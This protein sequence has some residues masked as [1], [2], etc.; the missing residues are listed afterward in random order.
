MASQHS[1]ELV[2][3]KDAGLIRS[4]ELA[5]YDAVLFYTT[6]DLTQPG[7][8]EGLFGGDGEPA[9]GP[10]G[11]QDLVAWVENGGAFLGFH[12]ATDTFHDPS[13]APSPYIEVLGGEF[14]T[15]G[16]QFPGK[17]DVVDPDHSTMAHIPKSWTLLDEW[18]VFKNVAVERVHV[19]ALLDTS[20]DPYD[21]EVY[22]RDPYPAIWCSSVGKGRVYYNAMG[23]REE[24]WDD[25]VFQQ[26]FLDALNWATGKTALDAEPNYRSVV[27]AASVS[28]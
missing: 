2:A 10:D 4:D 6:G 16:R 14:L 22:D 28:Q 15:H 11:V 7:T 26:A 1:F 5:K 21:Q 23:H 3:T 24:T 9:M 19:L 12:S 13:G 8:G 17:L 20:S 18:Y 25:R 27:P